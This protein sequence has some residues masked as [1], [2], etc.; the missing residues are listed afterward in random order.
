[1]SDLSELMQ[2]FYSETGQPPVK[3]Y[4][5][6]SG[7]ED[8]LPTFEYIQWLEERYQVKNQTAKLIVVKSIVAMRNFL[9]AQNMEAITRLIFV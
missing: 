4:V 9:R 3:W 1:M 8:C 7:Y 5:K 2:E 6:E